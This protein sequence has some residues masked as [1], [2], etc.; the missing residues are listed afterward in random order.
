MPEILNYT[1]EL[2]RKYIHISSSIIAI[3]L[4]VLGKNIFLPYLLFATI[5][6]CIL[7]FSRKHKPSLQKFY[8]NY[9][10][11]I[12][13]PNEQ[14]T[15]SGATWIF[16][17]STITIMA[18]NENIAIISLLIMSISDSAAAIIGIKYGKTKLFN[19]SLEGSIAFLFTTAL[20]VFIL[21]PAY[22]IINIFSVLTATFI[23]LLSTPTLNDN[24]LIP[25]STGIILTIGVIL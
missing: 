7:D 23:E 16:I 15:V 10:G 24:L 19:K 3:L 1:H 4:W 18:F 20:I 14:N 25:I 5:T 21:S 12:T 17:G 6:F 13:R 9:F 11:I 8:L 2:Y 22:F